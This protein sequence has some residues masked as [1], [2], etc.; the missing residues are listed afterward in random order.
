MVSKVLMVTFVYFAHSLVKPCRGKGDHYRLG[1]D[2]ID[3]VSTPT[4]VTEL[5][6]KCIVQ[7]AVGALHTL[8]LTTAGEVCYTCTWLIVYVQVRWSVVT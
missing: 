2:G 5:E 3:S 6:G 7:V 1:H 8:A 4:V